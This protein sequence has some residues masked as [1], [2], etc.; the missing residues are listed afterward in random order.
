MSRAHKPGTRKPCRDQ[1]TFS[2]VVLAV[3]LGAFCSTS[4]SANETR[5]V[6]QPES[7]PGRVAKLREKLSRPDISVVGQS[8]KSGQIIEMQWVNWPN[9]GNWNNWR[10]WNNWNNWLNWSNY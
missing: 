7:I 3:A 10:N 4:V 5:I 1:K 9:W 8:D 6:H 2:S